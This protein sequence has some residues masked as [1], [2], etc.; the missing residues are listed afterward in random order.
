MFPIRVAH[1]FR[2]YHINDYAFSFC[3]RLSS[4]SIGTGLKR[5]GKCCFEHCIRLRGISLPNDL[6]EIGSGA[7]RCSGITE[8]RIPEKIHEISASCFSGSKIRKVILPSQLDK[9][10]LF[11][12][13][14]CNMDN[15]DVPKEKQEIESNIY[16]GEE[17]TPFVG[18][19]FDTD[20]GQKERED[21]V[22]K[23]GSKLVKIS[24][25]YAKMDI[26]M[27]NDI[28]AKVMYTIDQ[29]VYTPI[30]HPTSKEKYGILTVVEKPNNV[31]PPDIIIITNGP[32]QEQYIVNGGKV[33]PCY[34]E[35]WAQGRFFVDSSLPASL[36]K[37]SSPCGT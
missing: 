23:N 24:I 26:C 32:Y 13:A 35:K 12:F 8:I 2:Y 18:T 11:A 7:F 1:L 29:V 9:V 36:T 17:F 22:K 25:D 34:K 10:S 28:W 21:F 6:R 3:Y 19:L 15:I 30:I 16:T 4:I 20:K 14:Y 5:I 37:I 27:D 31:T 33:L